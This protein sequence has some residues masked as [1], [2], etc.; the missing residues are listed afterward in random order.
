[1]D[2][3]KVASTSFSM[4]SRLS[5]THYF[6]SKE[7]KGDMRKVASTAGIIMYIM[8]CTRLDISHANSICS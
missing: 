5:E 4:L 1:M 2:S 3:A 6:T 8:V 7:E